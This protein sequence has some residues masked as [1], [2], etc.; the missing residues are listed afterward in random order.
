MA[1]EIREATAADAPALCDVH[2]ASI[3]GLGPE[4]YDDRQVEAWARGREPGDYPIETDETHVL[5]AE[6]EDR[7]VGFGWLKPA[8]DDYVEHD[9]DAEITAVYVHPNVAGEGIG[10]GIYERLEARARDAGATSLG[11]WASRNAVAFYEAHGFE[12]VTVHEIA[13]DDE[14]TGTVLEMRQSLE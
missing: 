2:V 13:F 3:T 14:I 11:L 4:A 10:S 1:G 5:V 7:V 12:G 9:V 8:A 6:R